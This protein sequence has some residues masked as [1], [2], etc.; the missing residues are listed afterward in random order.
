MRKTS[1]VTRKNM[2]SRRPGAARVCE[3]ASITHN[4]RERT[5]RKNALDKFPF[6]LRFAAGL[7]LTTGSSLVGVFRPTAPFRTSLLA[8]P[9]TGRL[10]DRA[11][12]FED[13]LR[14]GRRVL[15]N[16][17]KQDFSRQS[18]GALAEVV[19][20]DA[21]LGL[22]QAYGYQR[23]PLPDSDGDGFYYV[24]LRKPR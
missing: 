9:I 3:E 11:R 8:P 21:R 14:L 2:A 16:G 12:V 15:A 4:I 18:L 1:G 24:L 10:M 7:D 22:Q 5:S 19:P 23:L 17:L 20:M 6:R 13:S